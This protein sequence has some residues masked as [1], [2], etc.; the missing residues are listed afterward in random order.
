MKMI[1]LPVSRREFLGVVIGGVGA[2]MCAGAMPGCVGQ[3]V[4]VGPE[5]VADA[6]GQTVLALTQ[7][8]YPGSR[9]IRTIVNRGAIQVVGIRGYDQGAYQYAVDGDI[10]GGGDRADASNAF[11]VER[12]ALRRGQRLQWFQVL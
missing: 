5:L 6:D 12:Y 2:S 10:V 9:D 7:R 1:R 11:A 4:P 8:A 3:F